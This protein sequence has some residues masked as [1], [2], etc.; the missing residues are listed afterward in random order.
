MTSQRMQRHVLTVGLEDFFQVDA[1]DRLIEPRQWSRF[2]RRLERSTARTLELLDASGTRATFFVLGWIADFVPELV[3]AI[4]DRGHEIASRGYDHRSVSTLDPASFREDLT[5][6]REAIERAA[7]V[8]VLGHR[9]A[10]LWYHPVNLWALDVLAAEGYAYDSSLAPFLRRFAHDPWRRHCHPVQTAHGPIWELP[11]STTRVLGQAVPIAGGNYVRQ[12][13]SK[14]IDR[15]IDRWMREEPAPFVMYFHVW[16]LDPEQ[17]RVAAPLLQRVRQYRNLDRMRDFLSRW[18][19]CQPFGTA[20]ALLDIEQPRLRS[21]PAS[22]GVPHVT[23]PAPA[24]PTLTPVTVVV[25]C[26]NEAHSLGSLASRLDALQRTLGH[27]YALSY[28]FVDDGSTDQTWSVL[29]RLFGSRTDVN[30]VRLPRNQGIAAAIRT[31]VLRA[32]TEIVCSIDVR[33]S[34]DPIVLGTMLPCLRDGVDM[35]T[36]SPYYVDGAVRNM[37]AW[38]LGLS[39]ALSRLYGLLL[40]SRI[41]SYTSC[42]RVYRRSQVA[43]C[44]ADRGGDLGITE[45]LGRMLLAGGNVVEVP[46]A[47]EVPVVA[48]PKL[49]LAGTIAGHLGLCG[50]LL[51]LRVRLAAREAARR[52]SGMTPSRVRQVTVS[53]AP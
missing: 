47:L 9:A 11:V 45:L 2:E 21:S 29:E 41:T 34:H 48:Q 30:R 13:P 3:R 16:E 24:G 17:P 32:R 36:A 43:A 20:A 1:F 39:R 18:I 46:A 31:G 42:F 51:G 22:Q 38:R 8:R 53:G 44:R 19:S 23:L 7:G 35:V 33:C 52:V 12:L 40:G 25:P 10:R 49:K 14:F 4:A 27:Q 6:S 50:S 15:R 26:F 28:V 37:P 5:R